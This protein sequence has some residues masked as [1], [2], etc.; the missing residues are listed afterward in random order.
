VRRVELVF[1]WVWYIITA[2]PMVAHA[3][4]R[5]DITGENV[6]TLVCW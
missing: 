5:G 3:A 6:A 2:V 1:R 4:L